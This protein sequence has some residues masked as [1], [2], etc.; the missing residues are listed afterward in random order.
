MLAT[1]NMDMI[2]EMK[3]L[4]DSQPAEFGPFPGNIIPKSRFE[5]FGFMRPGAYNVASKAPGFKKLN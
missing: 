2:A 3:V 1:P 4:T 5:W